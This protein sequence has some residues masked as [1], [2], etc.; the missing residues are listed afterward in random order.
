MFTIETRPGRLYRRYPTPPPFSLTKKRKGG[1]GSPGGTPAGCGDQK[2]RVPGLSSSSRNR[3]RGPTRV[4]SPCLPQGLQFLFSLEDTKYQD[5]IC[6]YS[7]R[8]GRSTRC[9]QE[10]EACMPPYSP[11][12]PHPPVPTAQRK[13]L[14][15]QESSAG[16]RSWP[17]ERSL[18][19]HEGKAEQ[20]SGQ[21]REKGEEGKGLLLSGPSEC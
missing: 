8:P 1:T 6:F 9:Q 4:D 5:H 18:A 11:E 14:G 15:H 17:G 10:Y 13:C 7:V 12:A 16:H 21:H 3:E 19:V 2:G 20:A